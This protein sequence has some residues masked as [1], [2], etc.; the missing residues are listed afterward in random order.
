MWLY[1]YAPP[2]Q[3]ILRLDKANFDAGDSPKYR[4]STTQTVGKMLDT[5]QRGI[6]EAMTDYSPYSS[7]RRRG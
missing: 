1:L 4:V 7:T 6:K 5:A 2:I 3:R